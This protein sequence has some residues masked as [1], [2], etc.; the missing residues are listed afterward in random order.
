MK[1]DTVTQSADDMLARRVEDFRIHPTAASFVELRSEL[2]HSGRGDLLSELCSFWAARDPNPRSAAEA[3]SEAGE[4]LAVMGLV[5]P[6]IDRLRRALELDPVNER[7]IDRLV[8]ALLERGDV[9]A[10]V[11]PI[12]VELAELGKRHDGRAKKGDP[13][14]VRRAEQHRMAAKLWHEYLGRVDRALWHWQQA[15]RLEPH[16]T[17]A[18]EQARS[19]YAS[20]GDHAMVAKLYRAELEVLGSSGSTERRARIHYELGRAAIRGKDFVEASRQLEEAVRL[21]PTSHQI[22]ETLGEAYAMSGRGP[23]AARKASDI[24]VELGRT[25]LEGRED[26]VGIQLLRRAVGVDPSSASGSKALEQALYT[27]RRWTDLDRLLRDRLT[28]VQNDGERRLILQRRAELY[29][30]PLPDPAGLIEVLGEL[31]GMEGPRGPTSAELRRLLGAARDFPSLARVLEQDIAALHGDADVDP[32]I[33]VAELLELA[34]LYREHLN[35]RDRAAELLHQALTVVPSH[36]EALAR[37]MD[38][39]RERRDWRGLLDLLEFALDNARAAEVPAEELVQRLEEIAQIAELRIGDIPRAIDAWQRVAEVVPGS[40]KVGEALRRLTARSK[41]WEQL[42]SSLEAEVA[43]ASSDSTR[44]EAMRRM[45]LTYRERQIEPRRAIEV[46]EQILANHPGDDAALKSLIE[47]Y[48]REGDDAGVARSLRRQLDLEADRMAKQ[49]AEAGMAGGSAESAR[50]WPVNRRAERLTALRRLALLCETRL[51]DVDGVVFACSGVLELLPGDRDA[52]E[53]MERVLERADDPR[54][55]QTL[56]YH[57][58]VAASPAERTRILRRLAKLAQ[59]ADDSLTALDRWE[60]ALRASPTDPEALAALAELYERGE[61][62]ALLAQILERIDGGRP[63]PERGTSEA[64]VR[65]GEFERYA[66]IVD[67]RLHDTTRSVRAWQRILE[68]SP[69]HPDALSAL[70]TIFRDGGKWRELASVLERQVPVFAV[71][72]PERATAAALEHA[73]LLEQRLGSPEDAIRALESLIRDLNPNHAGAHSALRRLHELRGDFDAAMRIAEREMYLAAEPMQKIAVGL[74][75]GIACRD[76]LANPTRALQ[77]FERVLTIDEHQP[78]ALTAA[79]ELYARLGRHRDQVR[80]LERLL[81]SVTDRD[82]RRDLQHRLAHV[83]AEHLAD[84]RGAMRWWLAAHQES[85]D[86]G[87]FTEVRRAAEQHGLWKE[88]AEAYID[89]RRR[90]GG[91]G[92]AGQSAVFVRLSRDLA[93]IVE[94]RLGDRTRAMAILIEAVAVAPRDEDLLTEIE[95]LAAEGDIKPQWKM[96]LDA[97]KI[98]AG[99]GSVA[100]RASFLRRRARVLDERL[101]DAKGAVAELLEAFAWEPSREEIRSHLYELAGRARTWA[102]LISVEGALAERATSNPLRIEALRRKA[103]LIEEHLKDAPRAF[104]CHLVSFLLDPDNSDTSSHLWR[105][106]RVIGRYRENDR[107]PKPEPAIATMHSQQVIMAI[108]STV[109]SQPAARG[110]HMRMLTEELSE[111]DL[112]SFNAPEGA[113]QVAATLKVG[114]QTQ[115]IDLTEFEMTEVKAEQT[116]DIG[117]AMDLGNGDSDDAYREVEGETEVSAG[118]ASSPPAVHRGPAPGRNGSP[119]GS[120][121]AVDA[122]RRGA[123]AATPGASGKALHSFDQTMELSTRDLSPAGTAT[124]NAVSGAPISPVIPESTLFSRGKGAA[125]PGRLPPLPPRPPQ[126]RP[127]GGPPAARKAQA[128]VRT[129]PLPGVPGGSFESPW[130][131]LAL[132]YQGLPANDPGTQLRWLYRA[133]EIWETGRKDIARAFDTLASAFQIARQWRR[134]VEN[135]PRPARDG[136]AE[137]RQIPEADAEVRARLHRIASDHSAWDRLAALYEALAEHAESAVEASELLMDVAAI[138]S[139]QKRPRDAEAQL[140]R[141]LGMRP[142]DMAARERLETLYR[143]ESRW[144]E[145]AASLEERTDP[146]LGMAAPEAERGQWLREL[147]ALYTTKL[148]HPHDAIETLERL[149]LLQPQDTEVLVQLADLNGS[150][151]RWSKA[152]ETLSR[153]VD[154]SEGSAQARDALRKIASIYEIELE[155]PDRAADAYRQLVANWPDDVAGWAALDALYTQNARWGEL[156]EVIRRRAGLSDEPLQRAALLARRAQVLLDWLDAPE[157]A[158]VSLRHARAITP[159]D[160]TLA[161]QLVIAL[162]RADRGREAA[163]ILE[164]RIDALADQGGPRGDLAALYIRLAQLRLELLVDVEGA[165]DALDAA[166]LLVPEHPTALTLYTQLASPDDDPRAFAEA[167]L[168]EADGT[169]DDDVRVAALMVAGAVLR[170]RAQ[171][172]SAARLAFERVLALRPYDS[173]ATWALAGL[174]EKGGDPESAARL[175]ENRLGTPALPVQERARI[176]TQLAAL[177]RAAGVE[178]AAERRLLEALA[179]VPDHLPA[180]VA[181]ADYYADRERWDDLESYLREVLEGTALAAAPAALTADLQR[182][183]AH[184]FEKLGREEDAYQTLLAADRLHR[185]H[186]LVKLALGENR[187]KARRWREAALHLAPLAHHEEA[188]RYPQE[189]AQGLYHA[190]LAEIRS[191]RPEKAHPLYLKAIELKPNFAPALQALA[192]VAMEQGDYRLASDLLTRQAASTDDSAE[193]LRLFEALGDMALMMLNDQERAHACFAAAVQ[194]ASPIEAKHVPLLQK[195]LACQDRKGD[196]AGGAR[197]SELLAAFGSSATERGARYLRAARDH[198]RVGDLV[199]ARAAADRAVD[200]D[201]YDL[202]AVDIASELALAAGDADAAAESLGRCLSSKDERDPAYRAA[203]LAR[204][205]SARAQR[206]DAMRA[207][208]ALDRA[209]ALAP[210][211][212]GATAARRTLVALL[213]DEEESADR[214]EDTGQR[215]QAMIEL[216]RAVTH[217]TGQLSDLVTWA[218]EL[219]RSDRGPIGR[220][221][222]EVAIAMGHVAD[223]HQNAFLTVHKAPAMRADEAYRSTLRAADYAMF[224]SSPPSPPS[225]QPLSQLGIA[226]F[227]AAPQ[228]WPDLHESLA[229]AGLSQQQRIPATS[230]AE[231]V[232]M[233][234]R[235]TTA[236]GAGPSVLYQREVGGPDVEV[237]CGATTLVVLGPRLCGAAAPPPPAEMRAILTRAAALTRPENLVFA[238]LPQPDVAR[239]VAAC[240]R[241]YGPPSLRQA[242]A[243]FVIDAD[244]QRAYEDMIRGLLTVKLRTRIEQALAAPELNELDL[245][246]AI[247]NC[248]RS[249]DC[250]ALA[251]GTELSAVVRVVV[252]RG[253]SALALVHTLAH[254]G[255][256]ALRARIRNGR[257]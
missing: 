247:A 174:V 251:L 22:R 72:D 162:V 86:L 225:S 57:A 196:R 236:V 253:A 65:V 156:A 59:A 147:A 128:S 38:H 255:W 254:P 172:V 180:V 154:I 105:L 158:A 150:V 26:G 227:E 12:E 252:A 173:D 138:R 14:I 204:L 203:L 256:P 124:I 241:M 5:E 164:S 16:R 64:A 213:R 62:W 81:P 107:S 237:V 30:G 149:R 112:S 58:S 145:L 242:A 106:A 221:A 181:L 192:E 190:A 178:P 19:L 78:D 170:D 140:R 123:A 130:E 122:S 88:L 199:R 63:L 188:A 11:E 39:F 223:V 6:A 243:R 42:V 248:Q 133:A 32:E 23:D 211:S 80:A 212:E 193:K 139:E 179:L 102:E 41:M 235:L 33:L 234:P 84:P 45:A 210:D 165:R 229:R 90:L 187:Y 118:P 136:A 144:V 148:L 48:E 166:L 20:L 8:E 183:L 15:W 50:Q 216:L 28:Q 232:A 206:G 56:E 51:A 233:W 27:A 89:E 176:L 143:E 24:F 116:T 119:I 31:V 197:T 3:W 131:E 66:E 189:V 222:F 75:I 76:R 191:L 40:A 92:G 195:L 249:A 93:Q 129:K 185:G 13:V 214:S 68:L 108:N 217:S 99:S 74:E 53:R 101:G 82:E 246:G 175:L 155:L 226:L 18:L 71:L 228:L 159:D 35:D 132:A 69:R 44:I 218:A 61:R 146:R 238:G 205:G 91:D 36:E 215:R 167:K 161:E 151:G 126:I 25:Q 10:A 245:A 67:H 194:A 85:P 230:H 83:V 250:A 168:R 34:A 141:V 21:E 240:V 17:D 152:I 160:P 134:T 94:R 29:R 7:A 239:L 113:A 87:S 96:L 109:A 97:Y 73:E 201:P 182:R 115:P 135:A 153:V 95:R 70:A 171:D 60:Q 114:D 137:V 46:Y 1:E 110:R 2:R 127:G 117:E 49:M 43:S 100:E 52:L 257:S 121:R 157:E 9:A 125:A 142:D 244:V 198:Q 120:H 54:L 37:Y 79:S 163:A 184:A 224:A 104:R 200:A 220:D 169:R 111:S 202:A 219:R 209:I 4:V 77:A 231:A 47:L 177:S 98:A 55:E 207:R 103:Q 186:L 208:L